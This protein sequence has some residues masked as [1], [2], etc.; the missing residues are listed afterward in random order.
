[1]PPEA[2]YSLEDT[3]AHQRRTVGD[4][5]GPRERVVV[6]R[7]IVTPGEQPGPGLGLPSHPCAE[8]VAHDVDARV[9]HPGQYGAEVVRELGRHAQGLTIR[10]YAEQLRTEKATSAQRQQLIR[11]MRQDLEP[12]LADAGYAEPLRSWSLPNLEDIETE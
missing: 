12:I 11:D 1:M 6:D 8:R 2:P 7:D 10:P 5:A 3:G 9:A 4:H